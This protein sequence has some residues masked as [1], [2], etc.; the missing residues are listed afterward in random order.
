MSDEEENP[1]VSGLAALVAVAVVVGLLA[2]IAVLLG[3]RLLGI[4]GDT[5]LASDEPAA[6]ATMYLPDPVETERAEDPAITLLPTDSEAQEPRTDRPAPSPTATRSS[7]GATKASLNLSASPLSAE[8]GESVMLSGTYVNGEGSVIDI[9]RKVDDGAWEEFN[10][11]AYVSGGVFQV[12]VQSYQPGKV[13]WKV[14][15]EANKVES[16]PVTVTYG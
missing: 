8:V 15:D 7:A 2:G 5:D 11:D 12:N 14:R 16:D 9:W 3:T 6:G 4:S 13:A 10:V 1:V